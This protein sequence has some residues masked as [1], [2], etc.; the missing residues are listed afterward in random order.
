MTEVAHAAVRRQARTRV[1]RIKH[2][3]LL[4]HATAETALLG[5]IDLSRARPTALAERKLSIRRL[6]PS[7]VPKKTSSTAVAKKMREPEIGANP[8]RI[9]ENDRLSAG[10]RIA[11]SRSKLLQV[12]RCVAVDSQARDDERNRLLPR[13][14]HWNR[15]APSRVV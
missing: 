3:P 12:Q 11:I 15:I 7:G 2:P 14:S 13:W 9:G 10:S 1:L 6:V 4:V 5:G 8:I